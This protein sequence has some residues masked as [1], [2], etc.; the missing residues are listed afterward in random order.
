MW[1]PPSLQSVHRVPVSS[2]GSAPR[3]G[4]VKIVFDVAD[5]DVADVRRTIAAAGFAVGSY[6]PP[7]REHRVGGSPAGW[8]RL[9]A[10][11]PMRKF[12]A[13]EQQSIV[14][15]FATAQ[16]ATGL[17]CIRVGTDVWTAGGGTDSVGD[18]EPRR[19]VP[20]TGSGLPAAP[21]PASRR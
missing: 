7:D 5:A 15:D 20:R 4:G 21:M 18:R 19:P 10:E 16:H 2:F 6:Y 1:L 9:G 11:R 8:V 14:A 3:E 17:S 13:T 12:T